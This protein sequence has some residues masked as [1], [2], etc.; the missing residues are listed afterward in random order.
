MKTP[1]E[2][3]DEWLFSTLGT[4]D[5]LPPRFHPIPSEIAEPFDEQ[6]KVF[7]ERVKKLDSLFL[8]NKK[9]E[10][11]MDFIDGGICDAVTDL[12][13]G[14]AIVGI[15]K[16]A[17]M[18]PLETFFR[19]FSHPLVLPDLGNSRIERRNGR[20]GEGLPTNYNDL[21]DLRRRDKRNPSPKHP[22]DPTR[23]SVAL[24]CMQIVWGFLAFHEIVHIV[25]GH[26]EYRFH[27]VA[28]VRYLF[29]L[30]R[31]GNSRILSN[32]D[33]DLQT[34]ELWADAK[35][36]SVTLGGLLTNSYGLLADSWFPRPQDKV[37]IW[38]FTM[39][40]LF[41]I[42]GIKIDPANLHGHSHPALALRFQR[43]V[44]AAQ[45]ELAQRFPELDEKEFWQAAFVGRQEAEKAIVYIG[46]KP[47]DKND[48][49]GIRDPRVDAHLNQLMDH[50]EHTLIPELQKYSRV[51]I[52]FISP[53]LRQVS[54]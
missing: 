6:R 48:V 22:N 33:L 42:W 20:H 18:L 24:L 17:I 43:V 12:C 27:Q 35:A 3:F 26:L 19:M 5:E 46:A 15:F 39:F 4:S 54:H 36:M 29:R 11:H 10:I 47:L 7:K 14:I 41:R 40:T 2:I 8:P 1:E 34:L 13:G 37:F 38:S 32:D 49:S 45:L 53:A 51:K 52:D 23:T 9:I 16:G 21:I 30:F 31:S 25:H 44:A 50:Y 28:G